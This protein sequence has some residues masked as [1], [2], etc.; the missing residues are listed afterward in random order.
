V[1]NPGVQGP[2][3]S[4]YQDQVR[5]TKQT[6]FFASV[7]FDLIPKVLTCSRWARAISCSRIPGRA[8]SASFDCFEAGAPAGGCV[9]DNYNLN[10][11][12]CATPSPASRAAAT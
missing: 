9:N 4:F 3:T 2:T 11:R 6:A 12:T 8:A 7:D 10:A 1:V 5:D